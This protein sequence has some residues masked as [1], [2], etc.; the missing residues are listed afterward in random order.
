[1]RNTKYILSYSEKLIRNASEENLMHNIIKNR[2]KNVLDFL[3]DKK[4]IEFC[5]CSYF[6]LETNKK[7]IKQAKKVMDDWGMHFC[8]SRSRFTIGPNIELE[9]KLSELFGSYSITF[10]SVSAAHISAL[11][12]I[13]SGA[14][15]ENENNKKSKVR[16]VF[17]QY[18]HAS[19]QYLKPI[20]AQEAEIKTVTHN[21]ISELQDNIREAKNKNQHCVYVCDGVYS[22]GGQAPVDKLLELSNNEGLILYIDDA[23]GT[24]VYG[25]RGQGYVA[26]KLSFWPDRLFVNF[27]LAKGFGCN[28]GGITVPNKR[29]EQIVRY[30]GQS[31]AF[32][33]P[34]DFS[35]VGA[36]LVVVELHLSGEIKKYQNRL[37]QLVEYFN[38]RM[39]PSED[40]PFN[41]ISMI[42]IGCEH[43]A[44]AVSK[45][46]LKE[47]F[48]LS[49]VFFPV[50]PRNQAKLRICLTVNHTER[51]IDQL[52]NAMQRHIG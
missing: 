13:A 20:L 50:V 39:F 26:S 35:I 23:H 3:S 33:G 8:C 19:M 7:V 46:L 25:D 28:G 41:P 34:L 11:P 32:S 21:S 52:C 5:N 29:A 14:L 45:A 9:S 22:M 12:L 1:M 31:Y 51:Q 47:G 4:I 44:I 36:A 38:D 2:S 48:Y 37:E 6:G 42:D 16:L 10:P 24:S 27:S 40:L 49:P 18:A 17:D 43:R 15:I 30:F